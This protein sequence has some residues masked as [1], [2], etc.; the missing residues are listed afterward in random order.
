MFFFFFPQENNVKTPC[1]VGWSLSS[2][3]WIHTGK[4]QCHT[5][6][7]THTPSQELLL[8]HQLPGYIQFP[9]ANHSTSI[10]FHLALGRR[11]NKTS[12]SNI[13][14]MF[15]GHPLADVHPWY[16]WDQTGDLIP[17]P[18]LQGVHNPVGYCIPYFTCAQKQEQAWLPGSLRAPLSS[19][20]LFLRLTP[21]REG[22]QY[23]PRFW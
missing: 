23:R 19:L 17:A 16:M 12:D 8:W 22:Q 20:S 1:A 9:A 14:L 18:S 15:M 5:P 3:M 4:C 21:S 11:L 6:Q 10:L 2:Q 7:D 13:L